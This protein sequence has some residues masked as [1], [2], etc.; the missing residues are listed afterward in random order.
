MAWQ[1]AALAQGESSA[2]RKNGTQALGKRHKMDVYQRYAW[3]EE[4]WTL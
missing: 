3:P 1:D 4:E 2:W